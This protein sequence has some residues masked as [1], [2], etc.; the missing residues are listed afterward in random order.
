M[1]P[2][3]L[4]NKEV[5]NITVDDNVLDPIT[6]SNYNPD[7]IVD[8]LDSGWHTIVITPT[9]NSGDLFRIGAVYTRDANAATKK[10]N[11]VTE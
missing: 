4:K 10:T 7:I 3:A 5:V 6:V 2:N 1:Y 11:S 9:F 8:G